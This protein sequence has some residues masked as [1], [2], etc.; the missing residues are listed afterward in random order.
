MGDRDRFHGVLLVDKPTGM[1]SHDVVGKVRRIVGQQTVGHTGTLD[2]LATGLLVM[3]LG[4]AT[5]ISQYLMIEEKEYLAQ[6]R[7]GVRSTTYDAEGVI[8]DPAS[9]TVPIITLDDISRILPDF[10]GSIRQRVPAY[11]SVQIDGKRLYKIARKGK[12]IA[13]PERE[14]VISSLCVVQYDPPFLALAVTCSKGT[15]VRSLAHDIGE[16]LGCGAYLSGLRRT[17]MGSFRIEQALTLEQLASRAGGGALPD[18]ISPIDSA[19][20]WG[21]IQIAEQF[22]ESVG[23]GRLP[24]WTDIAG[25]RGDFRAGDRVIV[26]DS[27][28]VLAMGVAGADSCQ[29][30]LHVGTPLTEYLRVLA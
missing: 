9:A 21:A 24:H 23:F 30:A 3:C 27:H 28:D 10:T 7:L 14:V 20:P 5:K 15:Y 26:K 13:L 17:R 22:S 2:P 29:F 4:K 12:E 25:Y 1:S 11:S 18:L 8:G 16:R 6:L 19:L